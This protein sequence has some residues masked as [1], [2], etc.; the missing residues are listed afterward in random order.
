MTCGILPRPS[1][2]SAPLVQPLQPPLVQRTSQQQVR[3]SRSL[4]Q[5]HLCHNHPPTAHQL[6]RRCPCRSRALHQQCLCHSQHQTSRR[7]VRQSQLFQ[8]LGT[9]LTTLHKH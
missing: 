9:C 5:Q 2:L 7:Q 3:H 6:S 1:L 4:H 8:L